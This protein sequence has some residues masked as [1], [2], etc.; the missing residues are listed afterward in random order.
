MRNILIF[1]ALFVTPGLFSQD[2]TTPLEKSGFDTLTSHARLLEF[3]TALDQE[4]DLLQV[5]MI[6]QSVEGRDIPA[7]FFSKGIFGTDER[8]ARVLIF[9]Q[10]HGNEPSGK[11]GAL[12]LAAR[13]LMPDCDSLFDHLDLALVPQVNPD[14]SERG[15]RRNANQADLNRDHLVLAQPETWALHQLFDEYLFE[16][17]MDVH[18]YYPYSA[19]WEEKGYLK[20]SEVAVGTLTNINVSRR[21]RAYAYETALPFLTGFI[22]SH[23]F[24]AFEYLPGGPPGAWMMRRSTF[25]INDGRQSLG[26]QHTL[27]FIQEGKNGRDTGLDNIERRALSQASGM[28]GLLSFAARHS[29]AIKSLVAQERAALLN[30]AP[31]EAVAIQMV[32]TTTGETLALPVFSIATNADSTVMV[33]DYRPQVQAT[34]SVKEPSGYLIPVASSELLEWAERQALNTRPYEPEE[35]DRIEAYFVHQIDSID[36][37]GD[38]IRCPVV[39][40]GPFPDHPATGEYLFITVD[41]LKRNLVVQALEPRSMLGLATYPPHRGMVKKGEAYPV[42]RVLRD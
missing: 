16:V 23:G 3:T 4:S 19:S 21:L 18:E 26:S 34:E 11:E 6:G 5:R 22:E 42:L 40:P 2:L 38:T 13:L 33:E 24:T 8:K 35:D 25:D 20:N 30:H 10:Q 41:Q 39:Q 37:E 27:S 17:T 7:L 28:L 9:A 14:G 1:I 31:R 32:H 29:T 15:Q 12:M 36:F